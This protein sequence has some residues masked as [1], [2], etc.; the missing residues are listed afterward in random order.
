MTPPGSDVADQEQG[1]ALDQIAKLTEANR[2]NPNPKRERRIVQ[3]RHQ[4][5]AELERGTPGPVPEPDFDAIEVVDGLSTVSVE[6]FTP[7][8]LRAGIEKTGCLL[9]PGV[10]ERARCEQM[11][12][13][14]ER[15]FTARDEALNTAE[16][17]KDV[18]YY[19]P[20]AVDKT[21]YELARRRKWLQSAGAI[22]TADSPRVTFELI[23]V[24]AESGLLETIGTYLGQR[25]AVSVNKWTLRKVLPGTDGDWHQ[26]GAFLGDDIR[27][28]NI[29]VALTDCGRDAPGMEL[30]TQNLDHI[31]ATGTEGARFDW[32]VSP[33]EVETLLGGEAPL[34]PA[35]KAGDALLFDEMSLHQ[36]AP[37]EGMP[38]N[39]YAIETWCFAPGAY[40]AKQVP[41]VL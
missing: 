22:W 20:L 4:A 30:V 13:S 23:D 29:W 19:A 21:K 12:E 25:P 36:T 15:A 6:N 34:S 24:F 27:A 8:A 2:R 35:F 37:S 3:L 17:T 33:R 40:P 41:L 28:M 16:G 14:I 10:L 7:G 26:D 1:S 32:S 9:I 38:N 5:F 39:R 11:I 31:V 18:A